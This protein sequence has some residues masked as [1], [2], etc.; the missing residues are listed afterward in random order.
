M[1]G[2][3]LV[4]AHVHLYEK[5]EL[6][7]GLDAAASSF[8]SARRAAGLQSSSS[9]C[10]IVVDPMG[11][12]GFGRLAD[13]G[14]AGWSVSRMNELT[15]QAVRKTDQTTIVILGGRQVRTE[16]GLEVLA[17]FVRDSLAEGLSLRRTVEEALRKGAIPVVPWGFGKWWGRRGRIVEGLLRSDLGG[18]TLIAD[19]AVRPHWMPEPR[20]FEVAKEL[21]IPVVA[22]S[23]PLPFRGE[24]RK[25]GRY[26]FVLAGTLN[27]EDPVTTLRDR[28]TKKKFDPEMY[29]R[30]EY[31]FGAVKLQLAMQLR[32]F[33]L[34]T[35][36]E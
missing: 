3:T 29:G 23:D 18:R 16:S 10:L 19:S 17:L 1:E 13:Q 34:F 5:F 31:P 36:D 15:L 8:S 26:G 20:T 27:A 2:K 22:G 12:D 6:A 11:S 4:D 28:L 30:R 25:I 24:E 33:S 9:D 35:D 7:A 14:A 32:R 21:G